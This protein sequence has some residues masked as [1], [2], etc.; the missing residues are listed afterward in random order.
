MI[1]IY[2]RDVSVRRC[3]DY[4]LLPHSADAQDS[5]TARCTKI[6]KKLFEKKGEGVISFE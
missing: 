5:Y 1:H 4:T 6:Q 2:E 3:K